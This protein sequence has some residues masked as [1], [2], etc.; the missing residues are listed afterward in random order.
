M[1]A[2]REGK[3]Q[4]TVNEI[5]KHVGKVPSMDDLENVL[6]N[7]VRPREVA[8]RADTILR[9]MRLCNFALDD[10]HAQIIKDFLLEHDV[11]VREE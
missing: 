4:S 11:D 7:E 10:D 6:K 2:A 9:L 5:Q 3:Q 1:Q 8:Y